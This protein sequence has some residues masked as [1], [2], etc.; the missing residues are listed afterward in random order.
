[1][2]DQANFPTPLLRN[3]HQSA[4]PNHIITLLQNI[5]LHISTTSNH[6][7]DRT[8]PYACRA[9]HGPGARRESDCLICQ[10]TLQPDTETVIHAACGRA[11]CCVCFE[12]WMAALPEPQELKCTICRYPPKRYNP[13]LRPISGDAPV[14]TYHYEKVVLAACAEKFKEIVNL[15][16]S[17][18]DQVEK[19]LTICNNIDNG[20]AQN[21]LAKTKG[22]D[23][24]FEREHNVMRATWSI[25]KAREDKRRAWILQEL[26]DLVAEKAEKETGVIMSKKKARERAKRRP[27]WKYRTM[28]DI[29]AAFIFGLSAVE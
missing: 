23:R 1:M 19:M 2:F 3:V 12:A 27:S 18:D 10:E 21:R 8:L 5:K 11:T 29:D 28:A 17:F 6:M 26:N 4:F 13:R 24:F 25:F 15:D 20:L 14:F 16:I 7:A 22:Y 9:S